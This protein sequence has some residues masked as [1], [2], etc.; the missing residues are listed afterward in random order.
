MTAVGLTHFS[1]FA[2]NFDTKQEDPKR[3]KIVIDN[4]N[5][6]KTLENLFYQNVVSVI[7]PKSSLYLIR[8]LNFDDCRIFYL[9]LP[10]W[11]WCICLK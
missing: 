11:K 9:S 1:I 4:N 10:N 8:F 2:N 3:C 6:K 5:K 7:D